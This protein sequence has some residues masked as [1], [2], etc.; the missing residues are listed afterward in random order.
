MPPITIDLRDGFDRDAVIIRVGGRE[1]CR[2][3]SVS[4]R[5]QVGLAK[6]ITVE[7]GGMTVVEIEVPSRNLSATIEVDATAPRHVG[8]DIDRDGGIRHE[9]SDAPFRYL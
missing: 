9:I 6:K 4:T 2:D 7:A 8:I 5:R 1:V 3:H